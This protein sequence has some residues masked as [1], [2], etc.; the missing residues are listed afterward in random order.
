MLLL[1]SSFP[2]NSTS[3]IESSEEKS[4]L[5]SKINLPYGSAAIFSINSSADL[6]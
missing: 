3:I 6:I 2:L 1:P 5:L 4:I